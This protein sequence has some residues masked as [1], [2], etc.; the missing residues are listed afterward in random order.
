M[1]NAPG[2]AH[3]AALT[4]YVHRYAGD[5]GRVVSCMERAIRLSPVHPVWYE[6]ALGCGLWQ[7]GRTAQAVEVLRYA[8]RRD[9]DFIPAFA[10][11]ASLLG[12]IGEVVE[13][14]SVFETLKSA[15][16]SFSAREWC[17]LLPFRDS[18]AREREFEGLMKA[19]VAAL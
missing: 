7:L 9:P 13:A 8:T 2:H 3:I 16:P 10:S 4:G 17:D 1:L 6:N 5:P 12:D 14:R 15:D 19:G 11:L 18:A